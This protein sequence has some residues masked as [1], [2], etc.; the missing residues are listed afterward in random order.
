MRIPLASINLVVLFLFSGCSY[1]DND[2]TNGSQT[3]IKLDKMQNWCIGRYSFQLPVSAELIGGSD[4]YNSFYIKNKKNAS[5]Y[6]LKKAYE[7]KLLEYS[8]NNMLIIE[9]RAEQVNDGKTVKVFKGKVGKDQRGANDVYAWVLMNKTLFLI[10][11]TY[12]TKFK[13]ESDEALN[14]LLNNLVARKNNEIP[15]QAGVCI[16]NGFIRNEGKVYRHSYNSIGFRLK[17]AP[18]VRVALEAEALSKPTP[19]L[20]ERTNYNLK[21]EG[22][23]AKAEAETKTIRKGVKAQNLGGKLE[24]VE[25]LV[26]TPMKGKDGVLATWEH[27]GTPGLATDPLVQLEVDTG[28]ENNNIKT[29]SINE[30]ESIHLYE[31]I[32]NTIKRF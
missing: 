10:N 20:I 32:L 14:H 29:A 27:L 4:R 21:K 18:S 17:D 31:V 28:Y 24:G 15:T 3:M 7:D 25:W 12:S 5:H 8:K 23:L 19:D 13:T 22:L 6:D 16:D 11:G 30:K 9:D 26:K 2:N 1:A